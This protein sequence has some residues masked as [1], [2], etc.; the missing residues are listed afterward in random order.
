VLALTR[1]VS[2]ALAA[3]QLTHQARVPIDV[4]AARVQ[5]AA[6]EQALREAGYTV[7]RLSAT[8]EM[9]DSVFIED[10]AIVFD[11]L[12]VV[13]RPGAETRRVEIP[14][15]TDALRPHRPVHTIQPPGTI[16]GGDVLV[17]GNRVYIGISSRTNA[18]AVLQMHA[19]L[20]P[21][22]YIVQ[23]IAVRGCLHLK[24][25][26]TA[27]TDDLLLVNPS[28]VNI[29]AFKNFQVVEIDSSEPMAA[30]ALRLRDRVIFPSAFP[31]TAERVAA[32]GLRLSLVDAS[33]LA[34]AEGAVT[35]CS[36]ILNT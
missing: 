21:F 32:S 1:E 3:C 9:P 17:V 24:S 18:D 25:A 19:L 8:A 7:V 23:D 15:V 34:K 5:H 20:S 13:T 33:E 35:C 2:D 29:R 14:A 28:L 12:A 4:G 10:I 22:G 36:L 26:V 16:D 6:Y 30:N 27:L 31:R 11:E